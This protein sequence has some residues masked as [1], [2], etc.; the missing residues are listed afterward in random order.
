M[1]IDVSWLV[2]VLCLSWKEGGGER[3]GGG[4]WL[5]A[6]AGRKLRQFQVASRVV[7]RAGEDGKWAQVREWLAA[8]ESV[9]SASLAG[10]SADLRLTGRFGP[11]HTRMQL[12]TPAQGMGGLAE[13]APCRR[14][15]R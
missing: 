4:G 8:A 7:G 6:M 1:S 9:Q 5:M 15:R 2:Q 13:A 12:T 10:P 3:R 11:V 14:R